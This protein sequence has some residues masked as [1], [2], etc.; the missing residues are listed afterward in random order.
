MK[1]FLAGATGAIGRRL[2]PMLVSHGH[3]VVAS[4]RG[5]DKVDL[6]RTLGATPVIADGLDRDSLVSA[7]IAADP[8]VVV[9]QM[10]A[11]G[12]VTDF[13]NWPTRRSR[14]PTAC[15]RRAPII[16]S[17]ERARPARGGSSPR[18]SAT[19]TTSGAVAR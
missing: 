2:I 3:D 14:S 19:G 6:L 10:T 7:I 1:V 9:H 13:R 15:A 17:R 18:A 11:L 16:S 4:T 5:A 8:E 12:G